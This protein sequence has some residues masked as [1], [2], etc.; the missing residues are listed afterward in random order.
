MVLSI[1]TPCLIGK[2]TLRSLTSSSTSAPAVAAR[3]LRGRARPG[4]RLGLVVA[5]RSTRSVRGSGRGLRGQLVG[6]DARSRSSHAG[7]VVMTAPWSARRCPRC[8]PEPRA[9][10]DCGSAASDRAPLGAGSSSGVTSR[11]TSI[12]REQ[13]GAKAQPVGPR[14]VVRRPS[15]RIG[16]SRSPGGASSRG[17][18]SSSPW[19]YGC[20]GAANSSCRSARSTTRPPYEH[21][22]LVAQPGDHAE[23]VRDHDQRGAVLDDQ[24]L[25]QGRGSGPGWS[26]PA[27]WS[28]RPR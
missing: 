13:R 12:S 16:V 6:V 11:Q 26:R 25:E 4:S 22:H 21:V 17:I 7:P 10:P 20:R 1:S 19:V 23:I 24:S 2:C 18:D 5:A 14:D 9:A 15:R 8:R 27:R 28:A 3:Q